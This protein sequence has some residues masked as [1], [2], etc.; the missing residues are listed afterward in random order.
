M[1]GK[2]RVL[3][4]GSNMVLAEHYTPVHGRRITATT[5]ET[6]TFERPHLIGFHLVRGPVPHV[7]ERFDLTE[8][9][10]N[11]TLTYSGELGTDFGAV[12][13]WWGDRVAAPWEAAV[14]ASFEQIRAEAERR[15]IAKSG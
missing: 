11:T 8:Q 5:L 7:T 12:G 10:G 2:L 4:R 6:V 13:A 3:E 14:Q 15:F 9:D 1:S